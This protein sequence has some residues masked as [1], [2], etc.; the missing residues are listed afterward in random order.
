MSDLW[1]PK[2]MIEKRYARS[3]KKM[4]GQYEQI[5]KTYTDP[6]AILSALQDYV[7]SAAFRKASEDLAMKVVTHLFTDG[8]KTWREA[9][10]VNGRGREIYDAL[11]DELRNTP[12]GGV[13]Y[14]LIQNNALLISTLPNDIAEQVTR[15]VAEFAQSGRRSEDIASK[16]KQLFPDATK[17]RADLIARTEV[18]KASTALTEARCQ[19]LGINWYNWRTSEDQRVRSSHKHMD[20]VLI[21]WHNPP[22]PEQLNHERAYGNYHAGNTFNCRCY[23]EPV[24]ALDYVKW[25]HKV[26]YN[27][28]IQL[29]TLA[30]FKKI[31]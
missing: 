1:V 19:N 5:I 12:I 17:A 16:I 10:R 29:M 4:Y 22:S 23:P 18:S 3:I 31:A 9:A 20:E 26:Y 24:M 7:A 21:N 25:P 30:Q 6:N 8:Q 15:E 27:N 2:L 13:Y 11:Q 14:G 28:T